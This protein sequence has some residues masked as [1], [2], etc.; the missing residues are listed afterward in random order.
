M[1]NVKLK[2]VNNIS[3]I[4]L[5]SFTLLSCSNE[6]VEIKNTVTAYNK[7]L[8]EALAKPDEHI[9]EYFTSNN[10]LSRIGAY[11]LFLKTQK[12]IMVSDLKELEFIETIVSEDRKTATLK[13]V[14]QWTFYYVDYKTREPVTEEEAIKYE[15]TYTVVKEKDHWVVD[16]IDIKEK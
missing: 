16:K 4:I 8:P 7:I 13:T 14:E 1:I 5:I 12:K 2:T 11:I 6:S 9:M 15:N 10:E 3:L